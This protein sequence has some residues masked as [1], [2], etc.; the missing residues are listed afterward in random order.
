LTTG[1][2]TPRPCTARPGRRSAS[3]SA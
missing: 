3:W 1:P 2:Q